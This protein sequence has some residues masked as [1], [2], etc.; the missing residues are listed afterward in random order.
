MTDKKETQ[1]KLKHIES[2]VK[3]L[4]KRDKFYIDKEK[5][6]FIYYYPKFSK[7]KV[8][9]LFVDLNESIEY[10]AKNDLPFPANDLEVMQYTQFLIIKHFTSLKAELQNKSY[11]VHIETMYKL[12]E[13]G[14]FERFMNEMFDLAEVYDLLDELDKLAQVGLELVNL[15]KAQQEELKEKLQSNFL[16]KEDG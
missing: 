5:T 10:V 12:I 7:T 9:E 4:A 15:E 11:E 14:L 2:K 16:K 3:E 13:T 8:Q 1:L 6:Q